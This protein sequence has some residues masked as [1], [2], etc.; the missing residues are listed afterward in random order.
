MTAQITIFTTMAAIILIVRHYLIKNIN[1]DKES[2]VTRCFKDAVNGY[3]AA[4]TRLRKK[5]NEE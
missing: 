1:S 3:K 5:S 2:F 4:F